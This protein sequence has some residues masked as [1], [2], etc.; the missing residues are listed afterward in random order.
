[1]FVNE[2][3]AM[4]LRFLIWWSPKPQPVLINAQIKCSVSI[5][6]LPLHTHPSP[7]SAWLCV[8]YDGASVLSG[9]SLGLVLW[10]QRQE[11][12]KK[13][14]LVFIHF[15]Q[16]WCRL[17]QLTWDSSFYPVTLSAHSSLSPGPRNSSLLFSFRPR[18]CKRILLP[19]QDSALLFVKLSS[20]YQ[21]WLNHRFLAVSL[22]DT[23]ALLSLCR[24]RTF[25]RWLFELSLHP[26]SFSLMVFPLHLQPCLGI[27]SW[28]TQTNPVASETQAFLYALAIKANRRTERVE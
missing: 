17:V 26:S 19:V 6:P 8:Q 25:I 12:R 21:I 10:K 3:C 18:V 20:N 9:F 16:V 7:L 28:K 11:T 27:G 5:F 2:M 14:V 4:P 15:L 22:G 23:F 1:M 24:N 13:E